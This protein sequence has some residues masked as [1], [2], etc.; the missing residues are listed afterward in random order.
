MCSRPQDKHTRPQAQGVGDTHSPSA[1]L[2]G[3]TPVLLPAVSWFIH[4]WCVELAR[5]ESHESGHHLQQLLQSPT[6]SQHP[7]WP[8]GCHPLAVLVCRRCHEPPLD[9]DAWGA[10]GTCQRCLLQQVQHQGPQ[11]W[12]GASR[13]I[14]KKASFFTAWES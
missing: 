4:R 1:S 3:P 11:L 7:P 5:P 6:R 12:R 14:Y 10:P 13:A 9:T 8:T 2:T